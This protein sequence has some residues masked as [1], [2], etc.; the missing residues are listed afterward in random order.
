MPRS[1]AGSR[2]RVDSAAAGDAL[3]LPPPDLAAVQELIEK[4]KSRARATTT[5]GKANKGGREPA[6]QAQDAP[7]SNTD[8]LN[9]KCGL[10]SARLVD[11]AWAFAVTFVTVYLTVAGYLLYRRTVGSSQDFP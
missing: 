10:T 8:A 7:R 1:S 6:G 9:D 5:Q 11:F 3:N 4:A 2:G